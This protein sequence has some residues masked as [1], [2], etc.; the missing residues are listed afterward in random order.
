MSLAWAPPIVAAAARVFRVFAPGFAVLV[1][2]VVFLAFESFDT[3]G[4]S[5]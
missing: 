2:F 1:G 3:R 4:Q 5:S